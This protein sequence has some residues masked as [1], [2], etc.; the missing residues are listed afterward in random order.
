MREA[1]RRR[2][3]HG[4]PLLSRGAGYAWVGSTAKQARLTP[5]FHPTAKGREKR[6]SRSSLSRKTSRQF[7]LIQLKRNQ[8][9]LPAW[10][11]ASLA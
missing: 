7:Q 8:Q 10:S 9:W 11:P 2:E 4:T 1:Q 5:V 3:Q 6:N